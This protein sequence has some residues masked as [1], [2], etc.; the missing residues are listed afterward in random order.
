MNYRDLEIM[1]KALERYVATSLPSIETARASEM[2]EEMNLT[3]LVARGAARIVDPAAVMNRS[4][5]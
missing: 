4:I 5:N 3:R 2:L 1:A